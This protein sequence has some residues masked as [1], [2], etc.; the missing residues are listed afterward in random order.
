MQFARENPV[1]RRH[2]DLQER[3]DKLEEVNI[4]VLL[5]SSDAHVRPPGDEA[6]Q[7]PL[8][9]ATRFPDNTKTSARA[10]R[11]GVL[12][13]SLLPWCLIFEPHEPRSFYLLIFNPIPRLCIVGIITGRCIINMIAT[14][15]GDG[16]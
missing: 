16:R 1:I 4:P 15:G 14:L 7:Q 5:L 3:K 11:R 12:M 8:D 2:L 13:F 9:A 6:A 10:I